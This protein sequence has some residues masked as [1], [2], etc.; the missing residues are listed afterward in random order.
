MNQREG[1][2]TLQSTAKGLFKVISE[3]CALSMPLTIYHIAS[4]PGNFAVEE[5][6]KMA[7]ARVIPLMIEGGKRKEVESLWC[8]EGELFLQCSPIKS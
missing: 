4:L 1:K 7:G 6:Q 3:F 8:G 2:V 5:G